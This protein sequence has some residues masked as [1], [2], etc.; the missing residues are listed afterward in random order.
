MRIIRNTLDSLQFE[1][2]KIGDV[3][4]GHDDNQVYMKTDEAYEFP[5]DHDH[6]LNA[7]KLAD[8]SLVKFNQW[9][10]VIKPQAVTLTI[11]ERKE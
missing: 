2:L 6:Y 1:H 4:I 11:E 10:R 5:D 9:E 8:G 3:F 7:V